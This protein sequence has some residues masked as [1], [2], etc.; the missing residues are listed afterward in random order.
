MKSHRKVAML[1]V[2]AEMHRRH[3]KAGYAAEK[4]VKRRTPV[5]MGL[6][7]QSYTHVVDPGG[8]RIGTNVEYAPYVE[9]GTGNYVSAE[10]KQLA[11][12]RL[13]GR[14]GK[15]PWVYYSPRLRRFVTTYGQKAQPHLLPGTIQAIPDMRKAYGGK[16][17]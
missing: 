15:T 5:D 16:T 14:T 8:V 2:R 13:R 1:D 9:F 6:L 4:H 11:D 3:D 12:N 17:R 7:R 10:G